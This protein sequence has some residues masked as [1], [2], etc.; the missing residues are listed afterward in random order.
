MPGRE[1]IEAACQAGRLK[2]AQ[3]NVAHLGPELAGALQAKSGGGRASVQNPQQ[4]GVNSAAVASFSICNRGQAEA[5]LAR[6][7]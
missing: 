5:N 4:I 1:A 6:I 7:S 2:Y 3:E